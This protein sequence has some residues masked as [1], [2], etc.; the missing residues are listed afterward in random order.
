VRVWQAMH[1]CECGKPCIRAMH[2]CDAAACHGCAVAQGLRVDKRLLRRMRK[3]PNAEHVFAPAC[4]RVKA[5]TELL[6][7]A[8][9]EVTVNF[10]YSWETATAEVTADS[11]KTRVTTE[12][13]MIASKEQCAKSSI[14]LKVP[15]DM[16][17][18]S[19][20]MPPAA[21]AAPASTP[22]RTSVHLHEAQSC[23]AESS[24]FGWRR[25]PRQMDTST[26]GPT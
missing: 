2:Q 10:G 11:F 15:G 6:L 21:A 20:C 16:L 24:W 26:C 7:A 4:N 25:L 1:A 22:T 12:M 17:T 5:K 23:P 19:W 3:A 13:P 14:L 9:M 8:E 18:T